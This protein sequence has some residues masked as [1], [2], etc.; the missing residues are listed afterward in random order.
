MAVFRVGIIGCGGRGKSH[1]RGYA[2][3]KDAKIVACA[4]PDRKNAAALAKENKIPKSRIYADYKKMLEKE[5]LDIV[6]IC[7]WTGLHTQMVID[8]AEAGV[9]AI[10]AEKP[11]APT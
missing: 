7:T 10:H 6:S 5:K 9:K 1:A 11:M 4:D 8:G 2:A 3:S